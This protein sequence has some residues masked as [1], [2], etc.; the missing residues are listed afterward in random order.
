VQNV[1]VKYDTASKA[2]FRVEREEFAG[3]NGPRRKQVPWFE[4]VIDFSVVISLSSSFCTP[5]TTSHIRRNRTANITKEQITL[6]ILNDCSIPR[7]R[8]VNAQRERATLTRD[9]YTVS[10]ASIV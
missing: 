8:E 5:Y 1:R 7:L 4:N 2:N 3:E 9:G 10:T 6:G